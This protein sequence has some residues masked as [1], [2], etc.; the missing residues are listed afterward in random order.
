MHKIPGFDG[1]Y[2]DD[3]LQVI[4]R[5][6]R[7]LAVFHDKD[8]YPRVNLAKGRGKDAPRK[9]R[10]LHQIVCA[11]FHGPCGDGEQV[12]HLD[13]NV[14]NYQPQN[15]CYSTVLVNNRDRI[16]HGTVPRGSKH[17]MAVLTESKVQA[18]RGLA[19]LRTSRKGPHSDI[20]IGALFGVDKSTIRLIRLN[21]I[22]RH[23]NV[24]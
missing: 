10:G 22:W 13:G 11:V 17:G 6:G 21:K 18:I 12:R 23:V 5:H 2:L 15:L 3:S 4:S 19:S 24:A 1:Y 8:G 9:H 14:R 16:A 7:P 20:S